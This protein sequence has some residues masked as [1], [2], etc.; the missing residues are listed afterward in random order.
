METCCLHHKKHR[1]LTHLVGQGLLIHLFPASHTIR[2]HSVKR[3]FDLAFMISL[4]SSAC[5][6]GEMLSLKCLSRYFCWLNDLTPYKCDHCS[7]PWIP[8]YC[9]YLE[10]QSI[11][12]FA[13]ILPSLKG[14]LTRFFISG[15]FIKYLP[16]GLCFTT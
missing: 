13:S 8:D 11:K 9:L 1:K 5:T 10:L 6:L 15:F 7:G 2:W 16:I 12:G 4:Y 14:S 3:Y